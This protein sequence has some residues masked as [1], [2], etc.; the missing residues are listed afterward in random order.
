MAEELFDIVDKNNNLLGITKPRSQVHKD[1]D[2]H[3]V[4]HV[5]VTNNKGE[6]LVHLRSPNKD[7]NP[8]KWDARFGGHVVAG[9]DYDETAVTEL[10]QEIGLQVSIDDLKA[11]NVHKYDGVTNR[12]FVKIYFYTFN[13]NIS[14]LKFNDGEVIDLKWMSPNEIVQAAEE[15]P[16]KWITSARNITNIIQ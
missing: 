16:E 9:N 15:S 12:E 8:T 3:R 2:W 1:G 4:V 5:Y 7:L 14:D 13:G 6:V 10:Y 11:G